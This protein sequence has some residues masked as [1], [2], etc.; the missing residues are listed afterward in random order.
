M[1]GGGQTEM[2]GDETSRRLAEAENNVARALLH[3]QRIRQA[4]LIGEFDPQAY[5]AALHAYRQAE[6]EAY[7]ARQTWARARNALPA[8][9]GPAPALP[10]DAVPQD[11]AAS[12]APSGAPPETPV[13]PPASA[14]AAAQPFEP[15]D[16]MRFARW[17]VRQGRLSE[18]DVE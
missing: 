11:G 13:D 14:G 5:D 6:H 10:D 15:T 2:S 12:D 7:D 8:A 17:L 3:L 18:W 16:R 4:I 1:E 9:S